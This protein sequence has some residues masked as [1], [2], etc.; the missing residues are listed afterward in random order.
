[1]PKK[2]SLKTVINKHL[3]KDK[4]VYIAEQYG[5]STKGSKKDLIEEIVS[6]RSPEKILLSFGVEELKNFLAEQG[7]SKSGT[8]NKLV[9]R[10]LSLIEMPKVK[11]K[12]KRGNTKKPSTKK[13][14]K[15][16]A[17][18]VA[19]YLKDATFG[20]IRINKEDDLE[21]YLFGRLE[22]FF[23]DKNAKVISQ[24]IGYRDRS[25]PDIILKRREETVIVELKYIRKQRDYEEGIT[26]AQKYSGDLENSKVIL[27]CHDPNKK[28]KQEIPHIQKVISIIK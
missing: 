11:T 6:K 3:D 17:D 7:H 22:D 13:S 8:K 27:F 16:L 18:E 15:S 9:E 24:A 14:K 4:V 28:I 10:A 2:P 19:R 26:Q 23:R 5:L 25:R 12:T 21:K 20:S 1:M